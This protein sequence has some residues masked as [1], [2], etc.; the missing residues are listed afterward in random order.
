VIPAMYPIQPYLEKIEWGQGGN[1]A[2]ADEYPPLH[3]YT[4]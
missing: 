3:P 4:I 2:Q 1:L